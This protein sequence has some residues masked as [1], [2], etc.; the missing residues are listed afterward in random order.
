MEVP[1]EETFEGLDL[2]SLDICDCWLTSKRCYYAIVMNTRK[3]RVFFFALH[4]MKVGGEH[5]IQWKYK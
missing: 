1:N 5:C 4:R 2:K 3:K